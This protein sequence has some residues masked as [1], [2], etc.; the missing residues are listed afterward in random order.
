MSIETLK[1]LIEDGFASMDARIKAADK[2]ANEAFKKANRPGYG[3]GS[4]APG[5]ESPEQRKALERAYIA[6]LAGDQAKTDSAIAEYKGLTAGTDP[7]G[8]YFVSPQ[9]SE[10]M[11]AKAIA[12]SPLSSLA[13]TITMRHGDTFEEIMDLEDAAAHWV[14]ETEARPDTVTP[15]VGKASIALH[16]LYAMPKASQKLIDIADIDV[17]GWLNDKIATA[18]ALAEGDAFING[19]GVKKPR[20]IIDLPFVAT[21]DSTRPWGE[22]QYIASGAASDFAASMPSDALMDMVYALKPAYRANASWLMNRATVNRIRKFKDGT[23]LYIWQPSMQR[24]E[25][26]SLLGF[27]VY[28]CEDLPNVG[29]DAIPVLFG[30]FQ[31]AYT[32]IRRPGTKLL[33][34]PYTD[35]PNVRLYSYGRVGGG[36]VNFEAIKGLKIAQ[37]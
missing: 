9:L 1:A 22:I 35:K 28:L 30:D 15:G 6:L 23:N 25:P 8:G 29:T 2:T 10:T 21:G 20:G 5:D 7:D 11:T 24:P 19:D 31:A 37:S 3:G 17:V 12:L 34:D 27:P 13:R 16:E 18:F 14:G 36:M 32:I 33:T 26:D 4:G